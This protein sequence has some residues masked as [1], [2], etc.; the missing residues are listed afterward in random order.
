[1]PSVVPIAL[2]GLATAGAFAS[3]HKA[4]EAS[5]GKINALGPTWITVGKAAHSLTCAIGANSPDTS[6]FKIRERAR[7]DC[8]KDILVEISGRT[9]LHKTS[10]TGTIRSRSGDSITI[11]GR[12]DVTCKLGTDSPAT[13]GHKIGEVVTVNCWRGVLLLLERTSDPPTTA[14]ISGR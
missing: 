2:L 6:L 10:I 13:A 7:I 11:D 5:V 8:V 14:G 12:L 3:P 9:K 1:L 4:N